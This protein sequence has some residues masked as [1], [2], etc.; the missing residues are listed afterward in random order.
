[1][2]GHTLTRYRFHRD[3][4]AE[5]FCEHGEHEAGEWVEWSEHLEA[6]S[7]ALSGLSLSQVQRLGVML[8]RYNADE[9]E[10]FL[11]AEDL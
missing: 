5:C 9:V 8:A 11:R 2:S 10:D 7:R 4:M 6:C 1:M 3:N